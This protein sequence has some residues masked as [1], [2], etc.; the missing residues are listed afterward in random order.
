M[1][2]T[3]LVAALALACVASNAE[4]RPRKA[5]PAAEPCFLF[6]EM[7]SVKPTP[8]YRGRTNWTKPRAW[9]GWWMRKHLGVANPAGNRARW[10]AGYGTRANGPAI[11][12]LVV[13]AR[14]K[15]GG[16]VGIITGRAADGRWIVLSGNDGNRVRER[17]R[18]LR[19]A[20]AYRWPAGGAGTFASRGQA[21]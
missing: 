8:S 14:G 9:C 3:L 17:P 18:S 7:A 4:A 13:F 19:G 2:R 10:W 20:I 11:G 5:K 21:L 1:I 6:C 16:H 12:V 15:R